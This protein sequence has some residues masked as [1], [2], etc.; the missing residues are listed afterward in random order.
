MSGKRNLSGKRGW[1]FQVV[2]FLQLALLQA[3]F[4]TTSVPFCC[5]HGRFN[6]WLTN[7][8]ELKQQQEF[9]EK[10]CFG[11]ALR[12]CWF[13]RGMLHVREKII[14]TINVHCIPVWIRKNSHRI[15]LAWIILR[16]W[17]RADP[18]ND[19]ALRSSDN[20]TFFLE[21]SSL[22]FA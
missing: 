21:I 2:C 11:S 14:N 20:V 16:V 10:H 22:V 15:W 5:R 7:V 6:F 8:A 18:H 12:L 1:L 3:V 13:E 17:M 9:R 19:S 4:I